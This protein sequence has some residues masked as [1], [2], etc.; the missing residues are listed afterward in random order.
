MVVVF[1]AQR[2]LVR[3]PPH[4]E[5]LDV[6][7]RRCQKALEDLDARGL[8]GAVGPEQAND[9]VPPH[10]ER[11]SVHGVKFSVG[12]AHVLDAEHVR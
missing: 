11:D 6:A 12:L 4:A 10:V 8:S 7:G 3:G 2:S 5:D 1:L 9:L